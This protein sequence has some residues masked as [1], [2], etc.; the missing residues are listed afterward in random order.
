MGGGHG[1]LEGDT[2]A[3]QAQT[4]RSI[5]RERDE[6]YFGYY[7]ML[8]H[9]QN[10][11][12]DSVRTAAY[13]EAICGNPADFA[14]KVV[15][16]VGAGTGILSFFAARAGA[17]RVYAIE[18]S[19]MARHAQRLV[20]SNGLAHVI[21]VIQGKV[22][23]V[24]IDEPVDVI[25]S[26]PMGVLLVHERMMES[27]IVARDRFL[28]PR[29][30]DGPFQVVAP[31]QMFPSRGTIALA[32]FSDIALYSDA[33]GKI[34]FWNSRDFYGVDLS[35]LTEGAATAQFSQA[36]V[37]PIDGRTL[38]AGAA[39]HSLDFCTVSVGEL[40][41]FTVPFA[42]TCTLTGLIHGLAGWFDVHFLGSA[43]PPRVLSTSPQSDTTHWYQVRFLLDHP[44]AVNIGQV[45]R[46]EMAFA[47]N[48][49]RSHDIEVRIGLDG[50]TPK[51]GV[52]VQRYSLQEQ[53][54]WNL[55][56]SALQPFSK[57]AVGLYEDC[58]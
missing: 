54:Y 13:Q 10:M 1:A 9:Q 2:T 7:G 58:F 4:E 36:I 42:F 55:N 12:L 15:L 18:A 46:G 56:Q 45:V 5:S 49:Q 23:D 34:S 20:E 3:S 40:C 37:G 51:R 26:E 22:E 50:C 41:A 25:I 30:G 48:D 39:V 47:A 52:K 27:F 14:G 19:G 6:T 21:T 44:I 29:T 57:E 11:L 35:A 24:T 53:Q 32:P 33:M 28:R 8:M 38:M 17:R 31:S 16:D 43:T